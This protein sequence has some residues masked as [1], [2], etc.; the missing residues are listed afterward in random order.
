ME[1][2]GYVHHAVMEVKNIK[3]QHGNDYV[4]I[5]F[6]KTLASSIEG[7][8]KW[9]SLII[10]EVGG[11]IRSVLCGA[12]DLDQKIIESIGDTSSK[13]ITSTGGAIHSTF[14]G[15]G[16]FFDGFVGGIGGTIKWICILIF[17]I[18]IVFIVNQLHKLKKLHAVLTQEAPQQLSVEPPPNIT[19]NQT[20]AIIIKKW[21]F[22][23]SLT[24]GIVVYP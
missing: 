23:R 20:V 2:L 10:R 7:V 14:S 6:G 21:C 5:D 13:V 12:G 9:S 3:Q 24:F 11:T 8:D 4:L 18:V 1:V 16:Q 17:V 22:I 19:E 15:F